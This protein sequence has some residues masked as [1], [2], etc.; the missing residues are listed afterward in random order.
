MSVERITLN[1]LFWKSKYSVCQFTSFL[2]Y[3]D[4]HNQ[5]KH[6]KLKPLCKHNQGDICRDLGLDRHKK[7]ESP[8][9]RFTLIFKIWNM[10]HY[11]NFW[12]K[13]KRLSSGWGM[14]LYQAKCCRLWSLWKSTRK[15][16]FPFQIHGALINRPLPQNIT[17]A[18]Y[19]L[20]YSAVVK[21][22]HHYGT[23]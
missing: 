21:W 18:A 10:E 11:K 9:A 1:N 7:V 22:R 15:I 4:S 3:S 12:P 19:K 17:K 23:S 20:I 13:Q 14:F 8:C 16:L 2:L 6:L 5:K